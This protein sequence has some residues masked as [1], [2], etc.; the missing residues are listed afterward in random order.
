MDVPL[1]R[2]AID[3]QTPIDQIAFSGNL[4]G[5]FYLD[6]IRLAA[7]KPIA[8]PSTAVLEEHTGAVPDV[9][10][11]DQNFPNPFNSSTVISFNLPTFSDATLTVYNLVGQKVATLL[12]D[13]RAAG[14]YTVRWDGRDDAGQTLA[15]GMYLYR[16]RAETQAITRKLL[17]LR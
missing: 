5:T 9:F 11:L 12:D 7:A 1:K 6:D 14:T 13:T 2:F 16:V 10:A 3:R 4:H 15:S 17:I 8:S